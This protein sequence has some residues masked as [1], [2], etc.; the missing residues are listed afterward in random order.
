MTTAIND[1][2]DARLLV[3]DGTTDADLATIVAATQQ[4]GLVLCGSAGMVAPL[5]ARLATGSRRTAPTPPDGDG[6]LLTV[7][8]SG[9]E[10]AQAQVRAAVAAGCMRARVAGPDWRGLDLLDAGSHPVG[11]W[12]LHLPAPEPGTSLE[13]PEA[14]VQAARLADLVAASVERLAPSDLLLVGGDTATFVLR[15]LGIEQLQVV[16]ELLPGIPL[17][18]GMDA[19]GVR[20]RIVLKPGS[21]GD[22]Q[23]LVTLWRMLR[24]DR[25]EPA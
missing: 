6:P 10:M 19:T 16:A 24:A 13:G 22:E 5:A 18:E 21:F 23:V 11:D 9:S 2:G 14:R 8:G 15:G 7:V 25:R 20:R 4:L 1:A 3:I 12:L 17:T